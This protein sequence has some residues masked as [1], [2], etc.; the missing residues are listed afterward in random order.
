MIFL[1]SHGYFNNRHMNQAQGADMLINRTIIVVVCLCILLSIFTEG[2]TSSALDLVAFSLLII[3]L[4]KKKNSS[5]HSPE[6]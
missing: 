5:S 6:H 3:Y 4:W 1:F 2:L